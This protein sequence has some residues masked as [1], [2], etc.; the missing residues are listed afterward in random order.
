MISDDPAANGGFA[1]ISKL[2][3]FLDLA[4]R[5]AVLAGNT[6]GLAW[7]AELIAAAGADV[8][9]FAPEPSDE[10]RALLA[11]GSRS[12]TVTLHQRPWVPAD[13]AGAA[14]AVADLATLSDAAAFKAAGAAAGVIVNTIDKGATCD[15]YFGAIVSRSPLMIGATTDGT[16]PIL[17]QAVRRAIEAAVPDWLGP[18]A[19]FAREIRPEIKRR[20]A[21]GRQRRIFW[22][23]F[24][25][26]AMAAPLDEPARAGILAAAE[27]IAATSRRTVGVI[28]EIAAPPSADCLRICDVKR[29]QSADVLI[30]EPGIAPAIRAY[31]RREATR[32]VLG[33]AG[34]PGEIAAGT[35]LQELEAMR[36]DGKRIV[37]IRK[38]S[39]AACCGRDA[40]CLKAA[41]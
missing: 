33:R 41:S 4:G 22:E 19:D 35:C 13:L 27:T 16:A 40:A 24:A 20:L 6:P 3:I 32:L 28:D 31:F 25:E 30:E 23:A 11:R 2:P 5:R 8:Q 1:A 34:M 21:P 9:V 12:G 29:L 26:R 18:W 38:R 7:K 14:I 10:L 39:A 15:F 37:I 17:G 36:A